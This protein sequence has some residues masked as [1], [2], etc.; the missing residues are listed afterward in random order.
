MNC[1]SCGAPVASDATQ[2]DHC[3]ARLATVACPSCFGMVFVGAKFC[4]HCGSAISRTEVPADVVEKCPRCK[5]KMDEV[6]I[7]KTKLHECAKCEGIWVDTAALQQ[8]CDDR[9]QQAAVLGM[10]ATLPQDE[11]PLE[12]SIHYLPCPICNE[13]MNRVNFAHCSHVIVNVCKQHG[14][15]LDR[16]ELRRIVEFIRAG[17]MDLARREEMAELDHK[18]EDLKMAQ[19]NIGAG[20]D[21][22][23]DTRSVPQRNYDDVVSGVASV[24]I[25]LI[26]AFFFKK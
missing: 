16:D 24:A 8:I 4:S 3:G 22:G 23:Y 6:V 15:W 1:P 25:N 12:T 11:I 14:T 7:G 20:A 5:V 18:R 13:L 9:E 26:S 10:A 19:M 21:I 17:G 2:C